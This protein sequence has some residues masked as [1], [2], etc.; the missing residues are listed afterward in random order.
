MTPTAQSHETAAPPRSTHPT[1]SANRVEGTA[2]Y[3]QAGERIG[4]IN[5]LMIEKVSGQVT[6]AIMTFGAVLG[7]GGDRYPL[8]WSLLTYDTDLNGYVI[9]ERRL[10]GA[11]SASGD[12]A[13]GDLPW[14]E[15]VYSY[16]AVAPY[17]MP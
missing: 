7:V 15:A 12:S 9:D 1:I 4:K 5:D 14:R 3:N 16:W 6:S 13:D 17:W 8:P 2:V 11:P 10:K